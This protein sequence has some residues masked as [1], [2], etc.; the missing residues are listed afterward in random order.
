[1]KL[2]FK[3][4]L[5]ACSALFVIIAIVRITNM[6]NYF[7]VPTGGNFPTI[8]IGDY[9]F[10]TNLIKPARFK[11][12]CYRRY[13]ESNKSVYYIQRLCGIEG[14]KVEIRNGDLFVND[15][16]CDSGF[17]LAHAYILSITEMDKLKEEVI[18]E[19]ESVIMIS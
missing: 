5:I 9:I 1:M 7:H 19:N 12:V 11:F 15:V 3:R 16:P 18:I 8:N 13:D 6:L 10:T 14:D 2:F 4:I 17:T